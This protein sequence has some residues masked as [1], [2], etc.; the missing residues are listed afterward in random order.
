[1]YVYRI[2]KPPSPCRQSLSRGSTPATGGR[3]GRAMS[4]DCS[5]IE[6]LKLDDQLSSLMMQ[7]AMA[8][9]DQIEEVLG[10]QSTL[11]TL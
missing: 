9:M 4:P 2:G 5:A 10:G 7:A 8:A 3:L 1:M 6:T 11:I